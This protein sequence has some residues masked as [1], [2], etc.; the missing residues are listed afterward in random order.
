MSAYIPRLRMFAGP[1]GSGKARAKRKWGGCSHRSGTIRLNTDLVRKPGGLLEYV[2]VHEML[3]LLE[4]KH[5]ERFVALLE[6]HYPSWR[7]ARAVLNELP[8]AA[9]RW[10]VE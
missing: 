1:N 6:Q 10:T 3:P 4:P 7:E 2:V 9:E 5:G 8:L